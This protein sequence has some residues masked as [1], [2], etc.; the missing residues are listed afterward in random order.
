MNAQETIMQ[1]V[2]ARLQLAPSLVDGGV[3][4]A[5]RR[6]LPEAKQ[7]QICVYFGGSVPQRTTIKGNPIDWLTAVRLE[8]Q[9]RGDADTSG[10]QAALALHAAAWER[11][12]GDPTLGGLV[13]GDLEPGAI[14][15]DEDEADVQLGVAI[16]T[17]QARHRT[18]NYTL[19]PLA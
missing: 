7:G 13:M 8:C 12:M 16:G 5:R 14:V 10:D 6:P 1:A 9:K 19:E 3:H 4:R 2:V 11:L 15:T 18:G 17:V